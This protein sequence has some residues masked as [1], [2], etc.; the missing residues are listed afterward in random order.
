M[1]SNSDNMPEGI[2]ASTIVTLCCKSTI[3]K[4][5]TIMAATIGKKAS[6]MIEVNTIIDLDLESPSRLIERP[7]DSMI[8][9]MHP[10]PK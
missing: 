6:F 2:A 8:K 4:Y 9:G 3:P 1:D 10:S 7:N 5:V